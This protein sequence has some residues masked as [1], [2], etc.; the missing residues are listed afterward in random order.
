MQFPVQRAS[1][2]FDF[3]EDISNLRRPHVC[4]IPCWTAVGEQERRFRPTLREL[5]EAVHDP[6]KGRLPSE[7]WSDW[8]GPLC[9][10]Q[11]ES[12]GAGT[13]GALFV[14]ERLTHAQIAQLKE[15]PF[16][17]KHSDILVR[18]AA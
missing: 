10:E 2:G 8:S 13:K 12:L 16:F 18:K 15:L 9:M 5:A 6:Q 4:E 17:K 3:A 1:R 7:T 11:I 14:K